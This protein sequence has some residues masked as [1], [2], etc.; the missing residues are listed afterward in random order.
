MRIR[1]LYLKNFSP[2]LA[3]TGK[4]IVDLDLSSVI[5]RMIVFI[6]P[7]G[8]GKTYILSHLQPFATVGSLD[9]RNADD[10]I[11]E[12]K[13]GCKIIEYE[14]DGHEYIITHTYTWTGK[15][16]A[17]SH[18]IIKD[19]TELN[20]NGNRSSF[21]DIVQLEFGIDQSFLRLVRIGAN[22]SNFITMK[23]TERKA[24]VA[25]LLKDT[26]TYLYLYKCWSADLRTINTKVN[27]LMNKITTFS[28]VPIE[29]L[30]ANMQ[31]FEDDRNDAMK[32][33]DHLKEKRAMHKAEA[34][35]ILGEK[36]I[37]QFFDS[38][39][40]GKKEFEDIQTHIQEL[41]KELSS[42]DALPSEKEIN[43]LIGK[44]EAELTQCTEEI[45]AT[46]EAYENCVKRYNKTLDKKRIQGD[47]THIETLQTQY[48][49]MLKQMDLIEQS[50]EHFKCKYSTSQLE[51]LLEDLNSMSILINQVCQ[52]DEKSI[53]FVYHA[54]SSIIEYSNKKVEILTARKFKVQKLMS[55]LQ[56]S[57][58]YEPTQ[59]MFLPPFCPTK[60]CPYFVTHPVTIKKRD[61]GKTN[62]E[63]QLLKYQDELKNLDIDI[64]HYQEYP[65]LYSKLM[66]LKEYWRNLSPIL[67]DIDALKIT[68][69]KKVLL[70]SNYNVFYDYDK[71]I[72]TIDLVKKRDLYYELTESI[73]AIKNELSQFDI[74]QAEDLN[75][76]LE[77]LT[78]E[79]EGLE[80]RLAEKEQ[81]K[82]QCQH[83][84]ESLNET[85]L[86]LSKKSQIE[87]NLSI[88]R[89]K[90]HSLH[91]DLAAMEIN[92][93]K[94]SDITKIMTGIDKDL[95]MAIDKLNEITHKI[96]ELRTK[97]NDISYTSKELEELLNEQKWMTA[98]VNAVGSKKGIPMK[99]VKIFFDSCRGTVND[100]LSMVSGEDFEIL[101]FRITEKDF[102]IP[103]LCNG[104]VVED[105]ANASQGQTSLSS[106][107]LS[108]A[109]VKELTSRG[110]NTT[111]DYNI[112]LLDEPD[113][114]LHKSDKPKLL[115]I[116]MKY[117]DDI[118][119]KQCFII[120]HSEDTYYGNDV[121]LVVTSSDEVINQD[122]YPNAIFI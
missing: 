104:V 52:Y 20:P 77:K 45:Q 7:I 59:V 85:Y 69:L 12:G 99:M 75:T 39:T 43:Q 89:D 17:K 94:L 41:E 116:I 81:T 38:L 60:T 71:I 11:I 107:A 31:D 122:K 26:E 48:N 10:P 46:T 83:Q 14:K 27:I 18:S 82:L 88:M 50:I 96:D 62:F 105:I 97:I 28:K 87:S 102:T 121:Q 32:K 95:V 68:E 58:E 64:Y 40:S 49:D 101:D 53:S 113:S 6:G 33:V 110:S 23:A 117:L 92:Y 74:H 65:I 61:G 47:E 112:P 22:V 63:P 84:L 3:G 51:S 56:F 36:T 19:G 79:K 80:K 44:T 108:F 111:S 93:E 67:K 30:K 35:T 119:S 24:F 5:N 118:H 109:L 114:A 78:E 66:S 106:L 73:K 16:H 57:E 25:N 103:Y 15:S 8:S 70:L 90:K 72:D 1:R 100:M 37:Q 55:N 76:L 86:R 21:L 34:N 54:D 98:M 120:S 9:V 13:D 91:E 42:Y 2:I 4:E 115:S 29:E